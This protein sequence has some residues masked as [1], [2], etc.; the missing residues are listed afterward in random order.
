LKW[1]VGEVEIFQ[2]VELEAGALIQSILK[3]ASPQAIRGIAWLY[4]NFADRAG[5]LKA[6]VQSFL[7]RSN[8]KNVLVDTCNGNKKVRRD[9]P[10]WAGLN[11]EFLTGLSD[12]GVKPEDVNFVVCTHLHTDHVGWNTRLKEDEWVP[13]FPNAAYLFV[14]DEYKYWERR[15]EVEI[16]D[17]KA[18]F[19]DSVTPVVKAGLAQLVE[20]DHRIDEH[21]SLLP[22]TG[23]TPS[24]VSILIESSGQRAV[25]SGDFLHHPCQIAQPQWTTGGDTYPEMATATRQRILNQIAD[26]DTLLIGSHFANPVAGRVVRTDE[27][28]RF[29]V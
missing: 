2:I 9:L 18:A 19:D 29:S 6:Q 10:E 25:I 15:P 28:L 27:G 23:H 17:D 20:K 16:A 14:R 21:V 7:I 12:I 3:E 8:G 24:H 13:T 4:P 1:A 22:T 5:N 11:T 26:S